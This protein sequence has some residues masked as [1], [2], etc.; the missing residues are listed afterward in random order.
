MSIIDS[1]EK[2][3][4]GITIPIINTNFYIRLIGGSVK[5]IILIHETGEMYNTHLD[6]RIFAD[7]KS[8]V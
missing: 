3:F 2:T 4:E 8:V 1:I 5:N 6:V 7:R